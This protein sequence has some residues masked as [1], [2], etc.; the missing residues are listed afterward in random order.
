VAAAQGRFED[1][2]WRVRKD[3]S[4][5]WANVIITALRDESGNLRGFSKI[6]RDLTERRQAEENARRLLQEEAARRAAQTSEEDARR[7]EA[8]ERAQREQLRVTLESIGDAIF[9]TDDQG[10][11]TLLNPVAERLT[12][13]H[14]EE[15]LGRPLDHVF[16]IVN[17][18]TGR[19]AENPVARVL[20]E[21]AV[22][23]LANHTVLI[24]KDGTKR[25]IDDSAA[26]IKD[27]AGKLTGVVLVFR[28]VTERRRA[29]EVLQRQNRELELAARQKDEFLAMLAHELRNPLAPIRNALEIV[30]LGGDTSEA[31]GELRE[32]MERQMTHLVRLV[33]DLLDVS[34]ITR[35]NIQLHTE[36]LSLPIA[37]QSAV[38]ASA[39]LIEAEN[40][41]LTVSMAPEPMH[42]VGDATRLAQAISNLLNNAAK[43]TPAGGRIWLTVERRD[44]QAVI[45]VKDN[46]I[47]I[48][49]EMLS[50]IFEMFTQVNRSSD[51]AQ[52]GLGIGLTLVKRLIEMHGGSVEAHSAG[53]GTGSE[54]IVRLPLVA[55]EDQSNAPCALQALNGPSRR[56]LVVD[57]NVDAAESLALM[58]RLSGHEV[59]TAHDGATA[60]HLAADFLPQFVLLDI[61]MPGMDGY[62]TGRRIRQVH[63][64]ENVA[65]IA[66]TGWGQEEDRT[67]TDNAGFQAHLVKPVDPAALQKI[68]SRR[69][70]RAVAR[71]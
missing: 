27:E 69:A 50:Q 24:S 33:D 26:P 62:E 59:R 35:G 54:F 32:M 2:G 52:G 29:E 11:I 7:A 42:L 40:H 53:P 15:V 66:L 45:R 36:C 55:T 39:P 6:T 58:L 16:N 13:W 49:P 9:A 34:R 61:G 5:F 22:V 47:G 4:Q 64:L 57:D 44:T 41:K 18:V 31:I 21:G 14:R 60:I 10:R 67:R 25:P 30:K 68:L 23:G 51:R 38:E 56:L 70:N 12:G 46:G 48:P 17:E 28:D 19:V 65:L 63:G 43:Y 8:A 3:G 1:E 20:Q 37:V 71:S